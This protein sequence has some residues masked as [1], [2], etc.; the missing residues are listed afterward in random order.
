MPTLRAA[1]LPLSGGH[2]TVNARPGGDA[3]G[4]IVD[5]QGMQ[6]GRL[7]IL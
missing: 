4:D 3:D 5:T 6:R 1:R 7:R 2:V